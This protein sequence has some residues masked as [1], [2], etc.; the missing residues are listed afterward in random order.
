M[1]G[2]GARRR[3]ARV[4]NPCHGW[5]VPPGPTRLRGRRK[6]RAGR[7]P[8]AVPSCIADAR[9]TAGCGPAAHRM[10]RVRPARAWCVPPAATGGGAMGK[11]SPLPVVPTRPGSNHGQAKTLAHGTQRPG[12][13]R[14]KRT[15]VAPAFLQRGK[16]LQSPGAIPC[17]AR[18]SGG[19]PRCGVPAEGTEAAG[20]AF[21]YTERN[22]AGQ[23]PG[24]VQA[25][26]NLRHRRDVGR[27][28]R[29]VII[30]AGAVRAG[31]ED[32]QRPGTRALHRI[33]HG[34]RSRP[35]W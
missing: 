20:V 7:V 34:R 19:N 27:H 2:I 31:H 14:R 35:C 22:R 32:H 4:E 26:G 29:G 10:T 24:A 1:R 9:R 13:N 25:Q 15:G 12:T 11:G 8:G 30:R 18:S 5:A 17:I 16:G 3:T 21:A 28:L 33:R 23:V 6:N